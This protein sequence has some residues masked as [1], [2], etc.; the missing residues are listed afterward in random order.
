MTKNFF[1]VGNPVK[2]SLSPKIHNFWFKE[3]KVDAIYEKKEIQEHELKNL[4]EDIRNDK[5]FG[6][7]ITV[8][9]KQK[10]IPFLDQLSELSKK[11]NSVNTVYKKDNKV[12]GDNT[13]VFGFVKSIKHHSIELKDQTVLILG[14]GGVVPSIISGLQELSV[15]KIFLMNRT[16]KKIENL[17][18]NFP[19]IELLN[20]GEIVEFDIIINATSVGLKIDDKINI[21]LN[22]LKKGKIFY[23]T[24]Y[25]PPM[26]NFLKAAKKDGHK[27]VNG[28]LMLIYQAQKSFEYWNNITPKVND[29]FFQ[30]FSND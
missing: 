21:D 13:D 3:N 15:K 14:G 1:I 23:D 25:N 11:T 4:I 30:F 12:I 7:N 27:I 24:I 17:K 26:T 18:K 29:K 5:I 2:H 22:N 10:I 20:W 16:L 6:V 19:K 28:E 9:F 8:P